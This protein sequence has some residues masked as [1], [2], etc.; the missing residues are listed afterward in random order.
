MALSRRIRPGSITGWPAVTRLPSRVGAR[1]R[2]LAA[3]ARRTRRRLGGLLLA[4][5]A[6]AQVLLSYRDSTT[7]PPLARG[8]W[9][10][11]RRWRWRRRTSA[12]M[13]NLPASPL[14]QKSARHH[15]PTVGGDAES[16][17]IASSAAVCPPLHADCLLSPAVPATAPPQAAS[18]SASESVS[19]PAGRRGPAR[20]PCPLLHCHHRHRLPTASRR[21]H[22]RRLPWQTHRSCTTD[23][24]LRRRGRRVPQHCAVVCATTPRLLC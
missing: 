1:W 14:P 10:R 13:R 23:F 4:E 11:Q 21:C 7:R 18:A 16:S 9:R 3:C 17:R 22:C 2:L 15:L 6:R 20:W 19:G 8:Q 5:A 24:L 12:K